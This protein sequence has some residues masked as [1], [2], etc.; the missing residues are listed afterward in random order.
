MA[1]F[2]YGHSLFTLCGEGSGHGVGA[3]A[4][5]LVEHVDGHA[6][7]ADE[8]EAVDD[9]LAA[10]LFLNLFCDKPVELATGCVVVLGLGE[11]IEVVD[12]GG[13]LVLV[14]EGILKGF[15]NRAP[16]SFHGSDGS[17]LH[18]ASARVEVVD[19]DFGVGLFFLEL[20]AEPVCDAGISFALKVH[21]HREIEVGRPK[22]G[23][24]LGVDGVLKF[25]INHDYAMFKRQ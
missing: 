18:A 8:L 16:R 22:F 15:D 19:E 7:V 13:N 11:G 9:V 5:L 25:G 3:C 6:V 14:F 12:E 10:F 1:P 21:C 4:E 2:L 23:I 17:E 24:D 20:D